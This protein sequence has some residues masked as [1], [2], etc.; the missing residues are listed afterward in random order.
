MR[1]LQFVKALSLLVSAVAVLTAADAGP[2]PATRK[3]RAKPPVAVTAQQEA[4]VLQFLRQHHTELAELLGHLQLSR[5]ADYNRAIR[6]IGHARERLRQF[7]KGDG[8][9]YELELQSWVIQSKIQL[10]VARLAMSDSESLR[11]EL[12]HLLAEQFDLK[13]RFSQVERDRTAERLQKLDEQLRRLADSRAELLEKEFLSLTR[14]S[15]RLKAKRKDA[16]AAK[17]AGK[18]TP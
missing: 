7:E 14:S 13:L 3:E 16:T 17:P 2:N 12:R 6:D 1:A 15:E 11:D 18:S 5:P 9:R 10:L 4:E 8:E